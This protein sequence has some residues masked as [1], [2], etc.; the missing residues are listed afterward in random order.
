MVADGAGVVVV[1]V[2]VGVVVVVGG[3]GVV[4]VELDP[5]GEALGV[6]EVGPD[7]EDVEGLAP[8]CELCV[9][10]PFV[11]VDDELVDAVGVL[12]DVIGFVRSPLRS[13]WVS[14]CCCT[15]VTSE[16]I[17]VGDPLAPSADNA[18]KRLKSALS[19]AISARDGWRFRVTTI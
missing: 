5:G 11:P 9:L 8:G 6:V 12:V 15:A 10:A 13:S 18:F 17:A 16:S 3:V 2:G 19:S 1:V 4:V 7:D 14:I